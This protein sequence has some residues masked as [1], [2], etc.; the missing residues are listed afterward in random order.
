VLL[1]RHRHASIVVSRGG[2]RDQ[3]AGHAPTEPVWLGE[4]PPV[5]GWHAHLTVL[6]H[7]M[8]HAV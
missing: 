6:D 4:K 7:L 2:I 8:Q 1:S 5:D 3:L